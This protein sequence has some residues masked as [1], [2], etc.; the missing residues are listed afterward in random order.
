[1]V[2]VL[3]RVAVPVAVPEGV[4]VPVAVPVAVLKGAVPEAVDGQAPMLRRLI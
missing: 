1:M 3:E 4:A 2:A